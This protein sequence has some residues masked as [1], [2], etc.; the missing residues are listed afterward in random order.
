[1]RALIVAIVVLTRVPVP[2]YG[3]I[4]D[5]DLRRGA[6]FY[7]LVGLGVGLILAVVWWIF[8]GLPAW[9]GATLTVTA[10]VF[11]T[12]ALHIDGLAD[13]A[14]AFGAGGDAERQLRILRDSM[15]GTY[16]V[17]AVVLSLL[18]Q[19]GAVSALTGASGLIVAHVVSRAVL[20]TLV[21]SARPAREDGLL[22][23]MGG[24]L[25]G[26]GLALAWLF[27]G[28]IG[29]WCL[30]WWFFP[31]L[32]AVTGTSGLISWHARRRIGGLT[33]DVLGAAQQVALVVVLIV[34]TLA[35]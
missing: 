13:T 4:T 28:I 12:G 7:P 31:A 15:L 33:G 9:L 35:G 16:G 29:L 8:G 11:L 21:A 22:A 18:L 27:S 2:V 1:M 6:P 5:E 34:A 19:V 24:R 32:L 14:D 20:T 26:K 23:R 10:G 25:S 3:D 30:G 17:V